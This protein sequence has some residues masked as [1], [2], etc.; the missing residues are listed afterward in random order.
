MEKVELFLGNHVQTLK[1]KVI[2]SLVSWILKVFLFVCS[3][4]FL[5][6][7]FFFNLTKK[8]QKN[9]HFMTRKSTVITT[10][11]DQRMQRSIS[12]HTVH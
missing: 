10:C 2:F 12:E 5:F 6:F 7:M 11:C 8:I 9:G 4:G 1:Y 3:F